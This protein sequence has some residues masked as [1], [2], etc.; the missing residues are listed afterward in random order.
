MWLSIKRLFHKPTKAQLWQMVLYYYI[1]EF[2]HD[3]LCTCVFRM[4]WLNLITQEERTLLQ[5]R[6]DQE[7]DGDVTF[8]RRFSSPGHSMQV[9][10]QLRINIIRSFI[11]EALLEEKMK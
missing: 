3:W 9:R 8:N 6:I 4:Y 11:E 7:L 2:Q 1:H 5:T 10:R